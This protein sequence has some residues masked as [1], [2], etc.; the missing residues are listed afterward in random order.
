[1]ITRTK[2]IDDESTACTCNSV[3]CPTLVSKEREK[4]KKNTD[5]LTKCRTIDMRRALVPRTRELSLTF[6]NWNSPP[7]S[8]RFCVVSFVFAAANR[9][10]WASHR[11]FMSD[12]CAATLLPYSHPH[13][14]EQH[15]RL[16]P[17]RNDFWPPLSLPFFTR[18][19]IRPRRRKIT[20]QLTFCFASVSGRATCFSSR[21]R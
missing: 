11:R 18:R 12:L 10:F 5:M 4:K 13:P 9:T 3:Q 17:R 21:G 8:H 16:K 7:R 19:I 6:D 15:P 1:M 20:V 2:V 14:I